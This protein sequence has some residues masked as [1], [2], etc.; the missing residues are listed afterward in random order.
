M[1]NHPPEPESLTAVILL[2]PMVL[3]IIALT[4]APTLVSLGLSF[5]EWDLLGPLQWVGFNHYLTL[6]SR[7]EMAQIAMATVIFSVTSTLL[8]IGLSLL[9]A[10]LAYRALQKVP[11]VSAFFRTACLLPLAT[12]MIAVALFWG[13]LF[14]P[15]IGAFN[16][17]LLML[18]WI[19]APVAWLYTQPWAMI[20]VITLEVWKTTGYN[21]LLLL[22]AL[23]SLPIERLEAAQLDGASGWRLARYQLIPALSPMLTFVSIVTLIHC[24]QAFDAIYLLTQGGP[25]NTTKVAVFALFEKAFLSL[26]VGQASALAMLLFFVIA[27]LTAAQWVC[28]KALKSNRPI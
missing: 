24:L 27:V 26:D 5:T 22:A 9:V 11:A 18:G 2:A 6:F 21:V 25:L 1:K 28:N 16:G 17:I 12:P 20:C 19:K 4:Y 14:D 15:A 3:G 8:E 7:I 23:E 10:L 13:W